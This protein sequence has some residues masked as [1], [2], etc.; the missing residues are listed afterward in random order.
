MFLKN[1]RKFINLCIGSN[2]FISTEYF[3]T[4]SRE[5]NVVSED[6]YIGLKILMLLST[7]HFLSAIEIILMKV[8]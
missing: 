1:T 2:L 6:S 5:L 8:T 3:S 4:F 7:M